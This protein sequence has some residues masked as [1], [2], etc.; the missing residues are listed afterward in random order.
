MDAVCSSRLK[1][2]L[3]GKINKRAIRVKLL[4]PLSLGPRNVLPCPSPLPSWSRETRAEGNA[5]AS[6]LAAVLGPNHRNTLPSPLL[7]PSVRGK[8]E[9]NTLAAVLVSS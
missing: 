3:L 2:M 4:Q 6:A 5:L 9:R 8:P 7:R 1:V